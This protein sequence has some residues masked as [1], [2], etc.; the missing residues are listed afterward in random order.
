MNEDP[1][2]R[3]KK[4]PVASVYLI[5]P[6]GRPLIAWSDTKN[7]VVGTKLYTAPRP[8]VQKRKP[9]VGLTHQ[10]VDKLAAMFTK[11]HHIVEML[12]REIEAKLKERNHV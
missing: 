11:G 2:S 5:A 3:V 1:R 6:N 12:A 8:V 7:V 10:E 4:K 9:W